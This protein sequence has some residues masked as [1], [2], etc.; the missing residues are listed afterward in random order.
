PQYILYVSI[1]ETRINTT[2]LLISLRVFDSNIKK[3]AGTLC[4]PLSQDSHA[5]SIY[6]YLSDYCSDSSSESPES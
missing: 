5:N 1:G 2:T 4:M 3:K 6:D